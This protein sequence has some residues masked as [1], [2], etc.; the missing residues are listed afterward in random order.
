MA[1][2]V[3]ELYVRFHEEH[4]LTEEESR[5]V[6]RVARF[7][8]TPAESRRV[9][10]QAFP[11]EVIAASG[12]ATGGRVL[13]H[14]ARFAADP[15]STIVLTGYQAGGTRGAALQAG[16]RS[17][18]IHGEDVPVRAEVVTLG[19]LSAHADWAEIVD[20]LRHFRA[21][22]REVFLTHG[23]PS[24]ADALRVHVRDALGWDCSV[25][26]YLQRVE[27]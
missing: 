11:M 4:R 3:T 9:D 15:R 27:L 23:D 1:T 14:L 22:P 6:C 5:R 20:W 17:L 13:H 25:P 24:A 8:N 7:V 12:M 10:A 21:P 26:D 19:N 2:D 16:A 18:R